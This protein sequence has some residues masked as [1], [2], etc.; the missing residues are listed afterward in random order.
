MNRL[1]NVAYCNFNDTHVTMGHRCGRCYNYG[2]GDAECRYS[3]AIQNLYRLY[4]DDVVPNNRICSVEDC[5]YKFLHTNAAHHCPICK[6]RDAHTLADCPQNKPSVSVSTV[7]YNIK[8]PICRADNSV[9]VVQDKKILGL[10]DKC[11]ICMDNSV[12][13]MFPNCYHCCIC[14]ACLKKFDNKN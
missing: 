5:K 7:V 9:S 6:K 13:I 8:C 2:H 10:S 12:E 1:C 14:L 11:C 3:A 4:K